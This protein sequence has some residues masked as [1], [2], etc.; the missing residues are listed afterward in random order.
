MRIL[1]RNLKRTYHTFLF[2]SHTMNVLL[3]KF[4]C[5]FFTGVRII[6]EMPGSVA[7]GTPYIIELYK[8]HGTVYL[9]MQYIEHRADRRLFV[10][11][12]LY[13]R[14]IQNAWYTRY[15]NAIYWILSRQGD[16]TLHLIVNRTRGLN[17]QLLTESYCRWLRTLSVVWFIYVQVLIVLPALE[18]AWDCKE[19]HFFYK[20]YI[21]LGEKTVM[22]TYNYSLATFPDTSRYCSW[23][24]AL[25]LG[26]SCQN[27]HCCRP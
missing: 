19:N 2:I 20:K 25:L 1:Q 5:N 12:G 6:K 23:V 4:R 14:I 10:F 15:K 16:C 27:S 24:D 13:N 22:E 3:F 18:L 9:K 26:F 7:S 11:V 17:T 8:M 21:G